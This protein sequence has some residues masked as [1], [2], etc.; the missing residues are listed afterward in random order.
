V[1]IPLEK[2]GRLFTVVHI[3]PTISRRSLFTVVHIPHTHGEENYQRCAHPSHPR[4]GRT[5]NVVHILS[6]PRGEHYD[7]NPLSY[8]RGDY[9]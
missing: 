3:P 1:H 5:I 9:Y 8:P 6:Y 2:E 7:I 4:E